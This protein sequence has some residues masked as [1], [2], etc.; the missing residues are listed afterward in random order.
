MSLW[1]ARHF[2]RISWRP[3]TALSL[4]CCALA[5]T[6]GCKSF[7]ESKAAPTPAKSSASTPT[8]TFTDVSGK[9]YQDGDGD[10]IEF[11]KDGKA[12]E[13]NKSDK[14][15]PGQIGEVGIR[16]IYNSLDFDLMTGAGAPVRSSG[17]YNQIGNTV[18]LSFAGPDEDTLTAGTSGSS[19]R[20]SP[21][22]K[23][24]AFTVNND[25]SLSGPPAGIWTH[26]AFAH[27]ILIQ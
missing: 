5:F 2:G 6:V 14:V 22:A 13:I 24:V 10:K 3:A 17:K 1:S 18:T 23:S 8:P 16:R 12:T 9:N 27:L 19:P 21:G 26:K 15:Y 4:C 25:G 11:G 7:K 20:P